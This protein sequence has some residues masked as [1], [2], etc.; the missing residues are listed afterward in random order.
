MKTGSLKMLSKLKW[1]I[2]R[3]GTILELM[4]NITARIT[5]VLSRNMYFFNSSALQKERIWYY[6]RAICYVTNPGTPW[7]LLRSLSC[8]VLLFSFSDY[9]PG[10]LKQQQWTKKAPLT[11]EDLNWN[12]ERI[13]FFMFHIKFSETL[14]FMS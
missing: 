4:E 13:L 1:F 8:S 9:G 14:Y 10:V 7:Y 5:F 6:R 2:M 12:G 3:E 11:L